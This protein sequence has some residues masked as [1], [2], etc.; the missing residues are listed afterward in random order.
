MFICDMGHDEF[1]RREELG[2]GL[3]Y[4]LVSG[5]INSD[6]ADLLCDFSDGGKTYSSRRILCVS[7]ALSERFKRIFAGRKRIGILI[8]PGFHGIVANYACVLSGL[9]PI[10]INFTLG[11][12]AAKSCFD[13][14]EIGAAIVSSTY[15]E[16][17]T[18]AN[19]SFPFPHEIVD[20][21]SL[22]SEISEAEISIADA[23]AENGAD[24]FCKKRGIEKFADNS[25]EATL[26]FTSGSEGA[27]KAAILTGRN[28]IAN[29]LQTKITGLFDDSDILL[30]NL[31]IFHSFGM[32]F[33]VWY[34]ALHGQR[35]VSLS[36]PIDIKNNVRA[37]REKRATAII[38]TPTFFRAY[39]KHATREDM[40][41]LRM[42]IAG[43]EKTP[44]GFEDLW[45]AAFGKTYREGYGLT[46]ASPVVGVNMPERNFEYFST[47]TRKGSIGKLFPGMSARILS[48][49]DGTTVLEAGESGLLSMRGANVFAGYLNN[50]EATSKTL[51]GDWL[52]TGD[53]ARI[54]EDG[55][56]FIDGRL[57]RFSKIG[58]EM[59][60]HATVE[61]T[62]ARELGLA[63][64]EVPKIAVGS[65]LDKAK[66]EALVLLST[67]DI[68]LSEAKEALRNAG[69]SN[70]WQPK[71]LVRVDSIPLLPTGKLDLKKI[72]E[73]SRG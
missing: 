5:L 66:G 62:L 32:L 18:K 11:R 3:A 63:D 50:P 37:V 9:N 69:I 25:S 31:P 39:L 71:Y 15:L 60:P 29:C 22:L 7:S 65:R 61:T 17:I 51:V 59:V 54:D 10:N 26:V 20:I 67:I 57:S 42:A 13:T 12:V 73:L 44:K 6:K 36:S 49:D 47:G 19:P 56:L 2:Y 40:Q 34:I 70:L 48:L 55:F 64:S 27:P 41:S 4:S 58:G 21:D 1:S 8:P 38:G 72:S 52:V 28:L 68:T 53:I 46:E 23:D 24:F 33:E 14:A 35:T 30:A 16:K 43:A 45:N